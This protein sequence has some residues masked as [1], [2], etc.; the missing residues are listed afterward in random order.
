MTFP[1]DKGLYYQAI[2]VAMC[3]AGVPCPEKSGDARAWMDSS[4]ANRLAVLSEYYTLC[5]RMLTDKQRER[6]KA[7]QDLALLIK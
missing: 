1:S 6:L 5:G 7:A 3:K 2:G 4:K